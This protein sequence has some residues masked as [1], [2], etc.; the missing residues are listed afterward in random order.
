MQLSVGQN[1]FYWAHGKPIKNSCDVKIHGTQDCSHLRFATGKERDQFKFL[2]QEK[3]HT[4]ADTD[5]YLT[6]VMRV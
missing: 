5:I 1:I 2:Y 3:E 4:C 6:Y